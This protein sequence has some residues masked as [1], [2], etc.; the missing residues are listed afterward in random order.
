VQTPAPP[1]S[2]P[3]SRP[4]TPSSW[5]S[6]AAGLF[7]SGGSSPRPASPSPTF[8]AVVTS[9]RTRRAVSAEASPLAALQQQLRIPMPELHHHHQA[10]PSPS[11]VRP[12]PRARTTSGMY[13]LGLGMRGG[14]VV[15][16]ESR[17]ASIVGTPQRLTEHQDAEDFGVE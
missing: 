15:P 16:A 12:G 14:V 9:P 7:A 8:G 4:A 5:T 2:S 3:S 17:K 10:A 6:L 13:M 11:S 1:L